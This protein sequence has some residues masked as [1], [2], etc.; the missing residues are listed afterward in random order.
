MLFV[1]QHQHRIDGN[2]SHQTSMIRLLGQEVSPQVREWAKELGVNS[3]LGPRL[4]SAAA[5]GGVPQC[6]RREAAARP[7]PRRP[8]SG[9]AAPGRSPRRCPSLRAQPTPS[10]P[11]PSPEPS[12]S[13]SD[14]RLGS[15]CRMTRLT[16]VKDVT[17]SALMAEP[18][19]ARR[20]R[21]VGSCRGGKGADLPL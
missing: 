4:P 14:A 5:R 7:A 8:P 10:S 2:V 13:T 17:H 3:P 9:R 16:G 18:V 1:V 19:A 20:R 11:S 15:R 6:R 21:Q 12:S